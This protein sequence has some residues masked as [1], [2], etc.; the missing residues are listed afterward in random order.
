MFSSRDHSTY[1]A[2]VR[3]PPPIISVVI[4]KIIVFEWYVRSICI[5]C[6]EEK[7]DQIQTRLVMNTPPEVR[8]DAHSMNG[9]VVCEFSARPISSQMSYAMID[10]AIVMN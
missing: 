1:Q 5:G 3:A 7:V 6:T 10:Q 8:D 2:V 9:G 4:S